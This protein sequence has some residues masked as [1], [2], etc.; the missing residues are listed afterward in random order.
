MK[1][2]LEC[3][4]RILRMRYSSLN[5]VSSL[6]AYLVGTPGNLWLNHL[7]PAWRALSN[8]MAPHLCTCLGRSRHARVQPTVCGRALHGVR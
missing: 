8:V 3:D 4:A 6:V 5:W 2:G 1:D 7:E